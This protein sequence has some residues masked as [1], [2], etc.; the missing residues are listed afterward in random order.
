MTDLTLPS[1]PSAAADRLEHYCVVLTRPI[2]FIGVLGM[3]LAAGVTVIDVLMRWLASTAITALNEIT[4]MVFAVAVAACIPAGLAGHVNLKVD[5]LARWLTGRV[6]AWLDAVGDLLLLLFFLLLTWRIAVFAGS[7]AAQ[8]RTTLILGWPI[9]PFMYA[10]ALLL[11]IGTLVQAMIAGDAMHRAL[12]G[13]AIAQGAQ[14]SA[15]VTAV[16]LGITLAA[17]ALIAF[18]LF[19]FA[20]LSR[21]ANRNIGLAV[22]IA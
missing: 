5:I 15:V 14:A 16:V 22:T 11:G 1:D 10:V 19:E 3:L 13:R 20:W 7:L 12:A 4:A 8:G 21:W 2:A 6:A 9:A 18:G 17:L